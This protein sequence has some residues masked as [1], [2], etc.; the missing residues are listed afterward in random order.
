MQPVRA[1]P[2]VVIQLNENILSQQEGYSLARCPAVL[3]NFVKKLAIA[4]QRVTPLVDIIL[5]LLWSFIC[6]IKS[7]YQGRCMRLIGQ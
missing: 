5:L 3:V 7:T 6:L 2:E 4:T 1:V